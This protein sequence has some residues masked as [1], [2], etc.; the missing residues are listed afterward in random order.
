ML[1]GNVKLDAIVCDPPYGIRHR[2]KAFKEQSNSN[3]S[4]DEIYTGMLELGA[5]YLKPTGR[6]VFLYHLDKSLQS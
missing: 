4:L 2:S 3:F 5:K 1:R 6:L